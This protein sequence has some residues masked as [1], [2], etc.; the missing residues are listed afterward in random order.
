MRLHGNLSSFPFTLLGLKAELRSIL[1]KSGA[2][3]DEIKERLA[4]ASGQQ[5]F[6]PAFVNGERV[7]R[8][9]DTVR[10]KTDGKAGDLTDAGGR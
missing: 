9:S 6:R 4:S 5:P 1:K 7:K 2:S 10:I 8:R 3:R